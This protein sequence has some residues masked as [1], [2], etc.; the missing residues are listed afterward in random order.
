MEIGQASTGGPRVPL[1][2]E[3]KLHRKGNNL[4]HYCGDANHNI[5]NCV[6]LS[7]SNAWQQTWRS[8]NSIVTTEFQVSPKDNSEE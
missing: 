7:I 8:Q 3:V 5:A 6:C 4:C 2:M 1:P